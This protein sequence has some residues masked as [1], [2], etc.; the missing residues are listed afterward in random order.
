MLAVLLRN[1]DTV[2]HNRARISRLLVTSP[3][4]TVTV[5]CNVAVAWRA[6]SAAI[7]EDGGIRPGVHA[8]GRGR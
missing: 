8:D 1:R 6:Y 2:V 3:H 7:G 4:C 5:K